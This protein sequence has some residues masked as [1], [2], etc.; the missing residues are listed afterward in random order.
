MGLVR[1]RKLSHENRESGI[2]SFIRGRERKRDANRQIIKTL[3]ERKHKRKYRQ[4]NI[5]SE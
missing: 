1:F 2:I 5:V 3:N 4:T